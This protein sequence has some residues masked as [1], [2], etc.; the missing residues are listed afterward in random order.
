MSVKVI[1]KEI[2]AS[3]VSGLA[4][5]LY[6]GLKQVLYDKTKAAIFYE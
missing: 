3:S 5:D 1:M 4:L 6:Y 2:G